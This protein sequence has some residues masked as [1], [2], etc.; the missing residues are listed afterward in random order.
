MDEVPWKAEDLVQ[1]PTVYLNGFSNQRQALD[2]T[3]IGVLD[4]QP[5]IRLRMSHG[6]AKSLA[7]KILDLLTTFE[8]QTDTMILTHEMVERFYVQGGGAA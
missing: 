6:C 8:E 3:I 4:A 7:L 5:V 1:L 2:F